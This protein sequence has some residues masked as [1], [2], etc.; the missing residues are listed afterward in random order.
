MLLF[1]NKDVR[2]CLHYAEEARQKGEG[3]LTPA[4]KEAFLDMERRW[5]SLARSY[6]RRSDSTASE[7]STVNP[8]HSK[9]NA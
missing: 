8:Q 5:I 7:R 9:P 4:G 2:K 6:N 3:A 1:L